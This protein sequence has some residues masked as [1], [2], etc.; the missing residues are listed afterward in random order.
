[1]S[2]T[3]FFKSC[4]ASSSA[5]KRISFS[6]ISTSFMG[7]SLVILLSLS[8]VCLGNVPH[9]DNTLTT[10]TSNPDPN[11]SSGSSVIDLKEWTPK[12]PF[13][14]SHDSNLTSNH[15]SSPSSSKHPAGHESKSERYQVASFDFNHVATPYIISLWIIIVG[16]AKIGKFLQTVFPVLYF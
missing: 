3:G 8:C 12:I 13:E 11:A 5:V 16:L 6:S 15:A 1:M 9:E 7:V 4:R 2:L 14:T 10:V